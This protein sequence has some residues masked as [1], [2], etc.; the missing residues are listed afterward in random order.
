MDHYINS[1]LQGN[2]V[3]GT[4][5]TLHLWTLNGTLLPEVNVLPT[6]KSKFLCC[7]VSEVGVAW[8]QAAVVWGPGGVTLVFH[9]VVH[10]LDV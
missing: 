1:H 6:G 10:H 3:T 4:D 8:E 5:S 7:A 9:W 2:I